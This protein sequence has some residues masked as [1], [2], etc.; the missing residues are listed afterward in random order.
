MPR[1]RTSGIDAPMVGGGGGGGMQATGTDFG[2][3][4]GLM[5]AG[6]SLMS[7]GDRLLQI[8]ERREAED[9][10]LFAARAELDWVERMD[11]MRQNA[12]PTGDN[13]VE[14]FRS[15]FERYQTETLEQYDHLGQRARA[16]LEQRLT[17]LQTN[18]LRFAIR[19]QAELRSQHQINQINELSDDAL[20]AIA[21]NPEVYDL[22]RDS[23][24]DAVGALDMDENDR[25][26]MLRE[27]E[28]NMAST[29]VGALIDGAASQSEVDQVM[30]V[31]GE[32]GELTDRLTG[33]HFARLQS[34]AE[35]RKRAIRT[36]QRSFAARANSQMANLRSLMAAGHEPDAALVRSIEND[37]ARAGEEGLDVAQDWQNLQSL[38][39]TVSDLQ[40]LD[41][42]QLAGA[43][44]DLQAMVD[45]N[46]TPLEFD[47]LRIAEALLNDR[48]GEERAAQSALE[49]A[50]TDFW[51]VNGDVLSQ[52]PDNVSPD[53][54]AEAL[55][56]AHLTNDAGVNIREALIEGG[57]QD[58]FGAATPEQLADVVSRLSM[59]TERD[60]IDQMHLDIATE[61]LDRLERDLNDNVLGAYSTRQQEVTP[62]DLSGDPQEV[63]S[64]IAERAAMVAQAES[65]YGRQADFFLPQEASRLAVEM[66]DWGVGERMAFAQMVIG[67]GGNLDQFTDDL[68][69]L[70]QV[71]MMLS[72]ND[73]L[74]SNAQQVMVAGNVVRQNGI[75]DMV[76]SADLVTLR[77]RVAELMPSF[78]HMTGDMPST[79]MDAVMNVAVMEL[80]RQGSSPA[81]TASGNVD[82]I[83][84]DA[85]Q[86][87]AG[88]TYDAE[89]EAV[90]G[91]SDDLGG[92]VIPRGVREDDLSSVIED[93]SYEEIVMMTGGADPIYGVHLAPGV[94]P[95]DIPQVQGSS[96]AGPQ[97]VMAPGED[98]YYLRDRSGAYL[99]NRDGSRTVFNLGADMIDSILTA[100]RAQ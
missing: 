91:W 46:A 20:T 68:P 74:T 38:Q 36:E 51:R 72:Y 5:Q 29:Y 54:L 93:A 58:A 96:I 64:Q 35:T 62:L 57:M 92:I 90:G 47:A 63:A 18:N 78:S 13:Y 31:V 65:T 77:G 98:N 55:V 86:T 52:D 59:T 69:E 85:I 37:L 25:T 14:N 94:N 39:M 2:G 48:I 34:S 73:A 24:I 4:E 44:A 8:R 26:A 61:M 49:S 83:I 50:A 95:D 66:Q 97:L 32:D 100:R 81:E 56:Y 89:G 12:D 79:F 16:D 80:N 7:A 22:T 30:A 84:E 3:G 71:G 87:V 60:A 19:D 23:M 70:A 6:R 99:I 76:N 75:G 40:S 9:V 11:T 15:E 53:I 28:S 41:L 17:S 45:D 82:T 33:E 1:L 10:R 42:E 21:N 67:N 27:L 43:V 88:R